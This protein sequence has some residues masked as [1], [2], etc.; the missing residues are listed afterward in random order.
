MNALYLKHVFY[1]FVLDML[2]S[3]HC[4]L[5][6]V[7]LKLVTDTI[8]VTGEDKVVALLFVHCIICTVLCALNSINVFYAFVLYVLYSTH[9]IL[10]IVLLKLVTDKP[11]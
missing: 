6:I 11:L 9:C 1:A 3:M 4:L 10:S 8:F 2:Y 7:I 5:S